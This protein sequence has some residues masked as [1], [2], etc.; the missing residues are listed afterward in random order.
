M[1]PRL[2]PTVPHVAQLTGII[3]TALEYSRLATWGTVGTTSLG[4]IPYELND[5]RIEL[6]SEESHLFSGQTARWRGLH[7]KHPTLG[8]AGYMR[9][10]YV[11]DG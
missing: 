6:S 4:D 1:S 10:S 8:A 11:V 3:L 2:A 5:S 7:I 9:G